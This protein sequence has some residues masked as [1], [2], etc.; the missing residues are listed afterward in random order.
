MQD[1]GIDGWC[2]KIA[3]RIIETGKA[4]FC[5]LQ[6]G[7]KSKNKNVAKACLIAIA[8]LSI[9][10]S[11]GPNS[12]KYSACEVLLEE[13]AQ[14]LHPGL[15]LEVRLL[16]CICIYNF[17]SGKGE[18]EMFICDIYVTIYKFY[19]KLYC[20]LGIHKLINFSEGVRE[21]LR[22]LSSVTWMADELHK[23]TYYLFSKS[24]SLLQLISYYNLEPLLKPQV[25]ATNIIE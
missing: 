6:E 7:L 14:F 13:I 4:T 5:G 15:E 1:T 10:I 3:R 12:L 22:R 19:T 24:V 23:A 9:E 8:W 16:A 17:S 18:L 25:K 11:K 21:S 2:C 20:D